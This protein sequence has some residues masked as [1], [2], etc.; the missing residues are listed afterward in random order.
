M[1]SEGMKDNFAWDVKLEGTITGG[2]CWDNLTRSR[3]QDPRALERFGYKVYSQNDEDGILQEIF[4]RI[5]TTNK[6]FVEF[7]TQDGLESIGHYLLLCGWSGLWIEGDEGA[8]KRLQSRFRPAIDAQRLRVLNAFITRDN[9]NSLITSAGMQGQ[10]DLLSVDVDGNDYYI[11]KAIDA[12]LPRVAIVEFNGKMPPDL[13]WKMAYDA[14]HIW[15]GSDRHGASL[16]AL[17]LLGREKGYTLV[18]TSLNGV[19][20]FFVRD[21]LVNDSFLAPHTAEYL[22]NP[23]RLDLKFVTNHP[24]RY[25]LGLQREGYGLLDYCDVELVMG[26]HSVEYWEGV[27]SKQ[28][29]WTS[30]EKSV[31]RLLKCRAGDTCVIPCLFPE[32]ASEGGEV[33]CE[34]DVSSNSPGGEKMYAVKGKNAI[35]IYDIGDLPQGAIIR[36]AI[37]HQKLWIPS[38]TT[39]SCDTRRLGIGIRFSEIEFLSAK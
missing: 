2:L 6:I 11:W 38:E 14:D 29:A 22:Y 17:E 26:F 12:V 23:L 25:F 19:N 1:V 27:S 32:Q 4:R 35:Y 15:D 28:F 7:G 16:K 37:C 18:G 31:L 34:L 36:L 24:S 10:I 3:M 39:E 13:D 21:D 5:G 20:A 9:I 33:I 8:V 30:E